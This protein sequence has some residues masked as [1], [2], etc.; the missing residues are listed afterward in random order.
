MLKTTQKELKNYSHCH[1][2]FGYKKV[3]GFFLGRQWG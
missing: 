2:Q 3:G 1:Q